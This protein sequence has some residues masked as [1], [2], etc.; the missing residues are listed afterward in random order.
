MFAVI[1]TGGKQYRVAPDDLLSVEKLPG[2]PGD[3]VELDSVLMVGTDDGLNVGAPLVEGAV[4]AAEVVEQTR[5]PKIVVFKKKRRKNHRRRNGHRQ[6]L[7]V[8]R[9]TEIL[10]DGKRPAKTAAKAPKAEAAP[11]PAEAP[12]AEPEAKA[13]PK[14]EADAPEAKKAP[15]KKAAPKKAAAKKPAAKKAP[16]KKTAAPKKAAAKKPAAKKA[17]AKK[18]AKKDEE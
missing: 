11:K 18:A 3:T 8:L 4:V 2:A 13:E 10:T 9:I 16:A 5:G 7:T 1:K 12:A 14:A 15:A 6:D 17:T